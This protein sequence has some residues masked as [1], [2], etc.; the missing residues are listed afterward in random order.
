LIRTAKERHLFRLFAFAVPRHA[1]YQYIHSRCVL[2]EKQY[3]SY[4]IFL[5]FELP[6]S[7][8]FHFLGAHI[9]EMRL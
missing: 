9:P 8:V 7:R 2:G 4:F 3:E 1:L 5:I 6:F